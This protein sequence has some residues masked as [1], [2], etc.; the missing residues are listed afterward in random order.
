MS[1]PLPISDFD[2][3]LS[4]PP[5]G[6]ARPFVTLNAPPGTLAPG[7]AAELRNYLASLDDITDDWRAF[8][9]EQLLDLVTRPLHAT[10]GRALAPAD[11]CAGCA[12][13]GDDCGTRRRYKAAVTLVRQI[14]RH[15]AAVVM[16]PGACRATR[17]YGHA[18]HVWFE[19]GWEHRVHR[20]AQRHH[21]TTDQAGQELTR[22]AARQEDW[23][24]SAFGPRNE[25]CGLFCHLTLNLDRLGQGPLVEVV[26]DT[27]LEWVAARER[28]HG[29]APVTHDLR[30]ESQRMP[31]PPPGRVIPFPVPM[32]S[33]RL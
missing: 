1:V 29:A 7:F 19:C 5:A 27:V 2:R 3:W 8:E 28:R 31:G 15:G 21:L 14:A 13:P 18:F 25:G 33:T 16:M 6:T 30:G 22:L 17:D 9:T 10:N 32:T 11:G 26:G 4:R 12:C 24:N 23:L 20:F